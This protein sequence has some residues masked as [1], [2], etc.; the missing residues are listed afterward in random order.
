M[1]L[2]THI[3]ENFA[4]IPFRFLNTW[5]PKAPTERRSELLNNGHR[6]STV[7][8]HG[9][10]K[11]PFGAVSSVAQDLKDPHLGAHPYSDQPTKE[12][13]DLSESASRRARVCLA[14]AVLTT[15]LGASNM[16]R[17]L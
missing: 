8:E 15:S 7:L 11:D 5:S 3:G 10:A 9:R 4:F 1:Y 17:K 12:V 6:S 2:P 16:H 14:I 13:G